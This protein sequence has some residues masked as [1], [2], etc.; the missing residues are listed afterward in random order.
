MNRDDHGN[1]PRLGN[2]VGENVEGS[3]ELGHTWHDGQ[4][5]RDGD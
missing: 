5:G 4:S 3:D 1:R 2:E